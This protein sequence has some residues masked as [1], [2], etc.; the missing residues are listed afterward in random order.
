MS[1][2]ALLLKTSIKLAT[3]FLFGSIGETITEKSGHL[4]MGIPGIMSIGAIGGV[5]GESIYIGIVGKNGIDP[6]LCILIPIIFTLIFGAIAGLFFSFMCVTLKS[7]Q[8][9]VGLTLTTF[10]GGLCGLFLS[11]DKLISKDFFYIPGKYFNSMIFPNAPQQPNW[12]VNAFFSQG[13]LTYL[14]ILLAIAVAIFFKKSRTGLSLRAVGENPA[15]ADA[16]GINVSRYKYMSTIIG[17]AIAALGGLFIVMDNNRG[18]FE[19][20]VIEGYGWLAV[21]LVIFTMWKTDLAIA[22]SFIFAV[23]YCIPNCFALP[24]DAMKLLKIAP[25]AMTIIV[26]II[27]SVLKV[28]DS[29]PPSSLGITYFREDR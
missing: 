29:Q 11:N 20:D 19:P 25:Y 3:V 16:V 1:S 27:T 17:S 6:F 2:L 23:L 10:G 12:F 18:T 8:N 28:K 13:F 21:A 9:V 4:N 24:G 14:A 22:G 15:T 5:L 26:L 7:N